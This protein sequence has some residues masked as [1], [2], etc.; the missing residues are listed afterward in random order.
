MPTIPVLNVASTFV[1]TSLEPALT[2]TL[3]ASGAAVA[4]RFIQFTQ[5]SEYMV[6]FDPNAALGT[7]VML[8]LEDWL[9]ER[10]SDSSDAAPNDSVIRAAIRAHVEEFVS[11]IAILPSM[12]K[13]AWLVLCPSTGW[14]ATHHKL[15]ALFRTF[16]NLVL[17]RVRGIS[18][19]TLLEWPAALTE[20][21]FEDHGAD[22]SSQVPF[23]G[24]GFEALGDSIGRRAAQTLTRGQASQSTGS[25]RSSELAAYLRNL[26]VRVRIE[27]ADAPGRE[28]VERILRTV[29][30]FS[31]KGENPT[32]SPAEVD[33]AMGAG[34]CFLVN[35]ADRVSDYGVAG[36]IVFHESADSLLVESMALSCTVL[37]K[38]VEFAVLSALG[39]IAT[40][41]GRAKI[42][43]EY[44]PSGRNQPMLSFLR[45]ITPEPEG[46]FALPAS[47][48]EEWIEKT[49]V[50]P[51]AWELAANGF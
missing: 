46:P 15:A 2:G 16:A 36:L 40:A 37:G 6:L 3:N 23:T 10:L 51:G 33:Q 27:P 39:R 45:Q 47:A 13:P 8:R 25:G 24:E 5:L 38:Q 18:G 22:C 48:V 30:S 1:A 43:F 12:G 11:Q 32:V 44:R 21:K 35:A 20:G 31:L 9:R 50:S 42:E 14:V 49:A 7:V 17:A 28:D 4:L 34:G 26:G 29:A 19:L 41:R